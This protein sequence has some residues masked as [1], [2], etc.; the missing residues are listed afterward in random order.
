MAVPDGFTLVPFEGQDVYVTTLPKGTVLYR[1]VDTTGKIAEDVFGVRTPT[2]H[3]L[4]PNY[5]VFFYPFP[6]VDSTIKEYSHFLV[7]VVANDIKL[8][9][10]LSPSPAIRGDRFEAAGPI[11]SCDTIPEDQHGC[12]LK[13]R[14]YDPCFKPAFRAAHPDVSGMI[15][16]AGMDQMSL[17][18]AVKNYAAP[19]GIRHHLH[20]YLTTYVDALGKPGVPEVILYPLTTRG[21]TDVLTP[22]RSDLEAWVAAHRDTASYVMWKGF[23][24]SDE[25]ILEFL[26]AATSPDAGETR[27][28]LDTRTG[29]YVLRHMADA[30]TQSHL[31]EVRVGEEWSI[32]KDTPDFR[33][34]REAVTIPYST[35]ADLKLKVAEVG[36][37]LADAVRTQSVDGTP[38]SK[39]PDRMAHALA[40]A[41]LYPMF[42]ALGF[43]IVLGEGELADFS[44]GPP[45][46][47]A[48]ETAGETP[49]MYD[50]IVMGAL[51][52]LPAEDASKTLPE[53]T[54]VKVSKTTRQEVPTPPYGNRLTGLYEPQMDPKHVPYAARVYPRL[55]ATLSESLL[56]RAYTESTKTFDVPLM[57]ETAATLTADLLQRAM[58]SNYTALCAKESD[59]AA[60]AQPCPHTAEVSLQNLEAVTD[61]LIEIDWDFGAKPGWVNH[62]FAARMHQREHYPHPYGD[63]TDEYDEEAP[64]EEPPE[65]APE[66]VGGRRRRTHRL[67]RVSRRRR[68][69]VRRRRAPTAA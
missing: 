41:A 57:I 32:T 24:R 14:D 20:K 63:W 52:A 68:R 34:K 46:K 30:E 66:E 61:L 45:E 13:G 27:M 2:G 22:L 15:G 35:E 6:F 44:Y 36:K 19:T 62:L 3:C 10:F 47:P 29:F 7:Y 65:E 1:G 17:V 5:N 4:P 11:T 60:S 40:E 25:D 54:E 64:A 9:T 12:G 56:R 18:R 67:R 16:I 51:K 58:E 50:A 26:E 21:T 42:V 38:K 33:F 28:M 53:K 37:T 31:V 43:H 8:A 39:Y 49:S 23:Y 69:Y 59:T 48:E 55:H